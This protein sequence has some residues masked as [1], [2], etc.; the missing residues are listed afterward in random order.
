MNL[1]WALVLV[2]YA[3]AVGLARR[4]KIDIPWRV[5]ALFYLLVLLFLFKPLTG[6]YV[7][8]PTDVAQ[9]IWPWAT[10]APAGLSKFNVSRYEM[11]DV[12][13]Q[14][15]PWAHQVRESWKDFQPPL[16]NGLS[17]TGYPLLANMQSAALSPLRLL[18]LPLPLGYAMTA[19]GAMKVLV[20]LTFT[21]L[22]AR[23][24]YDELPSVIG[25]IAFGFGSFVI[26]WIHWP[27]AT[28]AV[29]LP[30]VAYAVDLLAE[31]RT[32]GRFVF[33]AVL[34]PM[35]VFGGHPATVVHVVFFAV[36]F[37]AWVIF[38]ESR[39]R[40]LQLVGTLVAVSVVAA[41]LAAPVLLPFV[42][43]MSETVRYQDLRAQPHSDGTP[44]S[45][46]VSLLP[47]VH[48][49]YGGRNE[50]ICGFAG[51]L[52]IAA[53]FG[54]LV[55]VI[56]KRDW[57][58]RE[59]FYVLA[60]V[61]VFAI[62]DDW[63]YVAPPFRHLMDMALNS[64]LRL[65]FCFLAALQT[66]ALVHHLRND[67]VALAATIAGG[68][69]V[70]LFI[71]VKG[72]PE[73]LPLVPGIVVLIVALTRVR[74]AVGVALVIELWLALHHTIPVRPLRELYP[75]TPLIRTLLR[76][77]GDQVYRMAGLDG[78][79]FP[80]TQAVFGLEDARVHDATS[81][82][83]YANAI[84]AAMPYDPI[85]YYPKF[86]DPHTPLLDALNVKWLVTDPGVNVGAR[87]KLLYDG[88]DG[89]IYENPTVKPRFVADTGR[90]DI[91]RAANNEY[92]LRVD[93]PHETTIKAS[94]TFWPGWRVKHNGKT[95]KPGVVDG[96]FIGFV[97]PPGKGTVT[98][99]YAPAS[100]W[101]GVI[102][103]I[104]M[105]ALLPIIRRRV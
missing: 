100:F 25:A 10:A 68:L 42:E 49:S 91:V 31:A 18:A 83:R 32:L 11:Q 95:L 78:A 27:H 2:V 62:V 1:T 71:Y 102:A 93:V 88:K 90:V 105:L 22:Y 87:W 52:G 24:R 43:G 21:F 39:E 77:R 37:S 55:R 9:L 85:E 72:R 29:F 80:N 74:L 92:E 46:F 64:R 48:P 40:R 33:A 69:A 96:A 82:M 44:Y 13:F 50:T 66:A 36:L 53:W 58:S 84:Q 5:A 17:G 28:V 4:A 75:K 57:R 47:L 89:R 70:L 59:F 103:A 99:K 73:P 8:F 15:A 34:G 6:P 101:G 63:P 65:L 3:A 61:L 98:L 51:L 86:K 12:V 30:A 67:R 26:A 45:D 14:M 76:E 56:V 104:V 97:V 20:A 16:W 60:L 94:I 81:S 7:S 79:L 19:E 38:V 35:I 54:L 41:V 23:R